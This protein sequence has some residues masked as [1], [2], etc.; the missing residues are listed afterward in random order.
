MWKGEIP[1]DVAVVLLHIVILADLV[2]DEREDEFTASVQNTAFLGYF[3]PF[4][5]LFV[6]MP[7]ACLM[8]T[9][10]PTVALSHVSLSHYSLSEQE[11]KTCKRGVE[12]K[13]KK[14]NVK[15]GGKKALFICIIAYF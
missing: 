3:H 1:S 11:R 10:F 12:I 6:G 8:Q 7:N 15:E 4:Q 9:S 13:K 14:K 5:E 2:W